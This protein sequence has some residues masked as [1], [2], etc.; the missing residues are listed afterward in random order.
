MLVAHGNQNRASSKVGPHIP[1]ARRKQGAHNSNSKLLNN[2]NSK[3]TF[4]A[5]LRSAG[6]ALVTA[7]RVAIPGVLQAWENSLKKANQT[8]HLASL[9]VKTSGKGAWS[10]TKWMAMQNPGAQNLL[11]TVRCPPKVAIALA[12]SARAFVLWSILFYAIKV[13]PNSTITKHLQNRN[14]PAGKAFGVAHNGASMFASVIRIGTLSLE[15]AELHKSAAVVYMR[16]GN[17]LTPIM[18]LS[19]RW[20]ICPLDGNTTVAI[21]NDHKVAKDWNLYIQ[22]SMDILGARGVEATKFLAQNGI[23]VRNATARYVANSANTTGRF[24][25]NSARAMGA[26]VVN[27]TSILNQ[28]VVA[29]LVIAEAD[30]TQLVNGSAQML[31][32]GTTRVANMG[33]RGVKGANR[34]LR[35][36]GASIATGV[37]KVFMATVA[38]IVFIIVTMGAVFSGKLPDTADVFM[39]K[40]AQ[41]DI[42]TVEGVL[43]KSLRLVKGSAAT[44]VQVGM[45]LAGVPWHIQAGVIAIGE[46]S[47]VKKLSQL[48][49][50]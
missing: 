41:W 30:I 21:P 7:R 16:S 50:I 45:M 35:D 17:P 34:A 13:R 38:C 20:T 25:R 49:P 15:Q 23:H 4:G 11:R 26:V 19:Q 5:R 1:V 47:K 33:E 28:Q 3:P 10:M 37:N 43:R 2:A 8:K 31:T 14:T 22:E 27:A 46:R 44:G 40:F 24:A 39:K 36:A 12:L 42:N 18:M 32:N 6:R 48:K 9:V 29:G